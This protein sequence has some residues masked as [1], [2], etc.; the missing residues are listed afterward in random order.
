M[1]P[2]ARHLRALPLA[3]VVTGCWALLPPYS[4]P[5]LN[6]ETR[7][8]VVDHVVP[9]VV[10]IVVSVAAI[11]LAPSR[12]SAEY[13]LVPGLVALLAGIWMT[14]THVPLVAQAARN[15]VSWPAAGYHT[16]PAVAVTVLGL[17]WV[18][19]NWSSPAQ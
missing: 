9:G 8:E 5:A 14:A 7:V 2:G 19:R 4:G 13:L 1:T 3:G 17:V 15:E 11:V 6:T 12:R 16:A 18:A 10:L